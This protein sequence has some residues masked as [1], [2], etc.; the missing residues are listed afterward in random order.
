MVEQACHETLAVAQARGIALAAD[1]P[2][3]TMAAVDSIAP[4]IIAS[5][6][7]DIVAERPSEMDAL[8][9]ALVRL[10]AEAGVA[11]PVHTFLY[12]SL[13]PQELR[14]RG[15]LPIPA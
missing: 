9:G 6:Q 5:L 15:T 8:I 3:K 4:G 1:S 12:H 11:T 7:R 14:A 10:G 13:L 2:A